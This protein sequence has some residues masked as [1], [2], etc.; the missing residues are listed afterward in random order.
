MGYIATGATVHGVR[1][2]RSVRGATESEARQ[3]LRQIE[4]EIVLG[5]PVTDGTIRLDRVIEE[6]LSATSSPPWARSD[7]E[8]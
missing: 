3:K 7:S 2:R 6:S 5:K 4:A 8:T 1:Q